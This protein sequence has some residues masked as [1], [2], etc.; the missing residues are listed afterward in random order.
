LVKE[1]SISESVSRPSELMH[2]AYNV[3]RTGAYPFLVALV[4]C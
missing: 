1:L 2:I 4:R 3:S